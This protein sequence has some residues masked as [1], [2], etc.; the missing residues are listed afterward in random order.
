MRLRGTAFDPGFLVLVA[1][2]LAVSCG[3]D[4]WRPG[5]CGPDDKCDERAG[6]GKC[7]EDDARCAEQETHREPVEEGTCVMSC[8]GGECGF[9]CN[10]SDDCTVDCSEG[11]CYVVCH[12][13]DRRETE[14]VGEEA[15]SSS[16]TV[17]AI[18][19]E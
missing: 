14:C 1:S 8:E 4:P 2:M 16:I 15:C 3:E 11:P 7:A 12:S 17:Q 6:S 13:R 9:E 18:R 10:M 5:I 19:R